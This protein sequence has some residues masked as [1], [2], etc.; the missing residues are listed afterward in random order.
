MATAL[1]VAEAVATVLPAKRDRRAAAA[2]D[3]VIRKQLGARPSRSRAAPRSPTT[4][5]RRPRRSSAASTRPGLFRKI[6]TD[7][8]AVLEIDD[9][10]VAAPRAKRLS[11][12][13]PLLGEVIHDPDRRT[14]VGGPPT[15]VVPKQELDAIAPEPTK[16]ASTTLT[17]TGGGSK[18]GLVLGIGLAVIAAGGVGV[19][20]MTRKTEPE[21]KIVVPPT[22]LADAVQ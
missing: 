15:G 1:D 19:W 18:R 2:L 4:S 9:T 16:S 12:G 20:A 3:D 21:P 14:E 11:E 7:G 22:Q 13:V 5:R 8:L 17:G 10:A 6:D